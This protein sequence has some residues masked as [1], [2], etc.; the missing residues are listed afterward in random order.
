VLALRWVDKKDLKRIAK[1]TGGTVCLTLATLDGDEKFEPS[2]LGQCDEV[3]EETV[4]DWDY[5]FFKGPKSTKATSIILRGAN[6]FMLDEM[7]RSVHDALCAVSR[8]LESSKVCAGGGAVEG[9]LSIYLEDFARTLGSRHQLAIAEFAEAL[10]VI[11]KTLAVNAAQDSTDLVARLRSFHAASQARS[12][13][14]KNAEYKWFGLDLLSGTLRNN[15]QFGVVEPLMSKVKAIRFATEAAVTILRID[16]L[17][18]IRPPPAE[19]EAD[20]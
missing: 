19:E 11:P 2:F 18:K 9:A 4:G 6:D 13:D 1:A 20:Q 5:I 10:L 15:I 12:A 3:V 16:D 14:G 7:E 8:T 17:I